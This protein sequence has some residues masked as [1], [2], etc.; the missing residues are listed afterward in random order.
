MGVILNDIKKFDKVEKINFFF[1]NYKDYVEN[2]WWLNV[3]IFID[4]EDFI[5][6]CGFNL[7]ILRNDYYFIVMDKNNGRFYVSICFIFGC[8]YFGMIV[9]EFDMFICFFLID[10]VRVKFFDRNILFILEMIEDYDV[11]NYVMNWI[12][13]YI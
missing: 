9:V 6:S 4:G 7:Y 5:F 2:I 10:E 8:N 11:L 1:V 3:G 12:N 13:I